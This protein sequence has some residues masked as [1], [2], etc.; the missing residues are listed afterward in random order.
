MEAGARN[1]TGSMG[2]KPVLE[3]SK[4]QGGL[5][6]L[7]PTHFMEIPMDKWSIFRNA[8]VSLLSSLNFLCLACSR[9]ADHDCRACDSGNIGICTLY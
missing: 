2:V 6:L 4:F 7:T 9:D 3:L 5:V 8:R 1:A